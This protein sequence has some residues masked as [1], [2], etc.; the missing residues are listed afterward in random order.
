MS[1]IS[2]ESGID[3]VLI[4]FRVLSGDCRK[5]R[6]LEDCTRLG[7][8]IEVF[9]ADRHYVPSLLCIAWPERDPDHFD[10]DDMVGRSVVLAFPCSFRAQVE[11]IMLTSTHELLISTVA[12]DLD[13]GSGKLLQVVP[14]DLE[15]A[16][17]NGGPWPLAR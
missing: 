7:E 13:S 17:L 8:I 3:P 6:I 1:L 10:N 5:H 11:S 12:L 14:F 2:W 4:F 15:G 9:P 16:S